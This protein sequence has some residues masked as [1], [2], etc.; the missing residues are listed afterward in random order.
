[1]PR[2][3]L[4]DKFFEDEV[5]EGFYIP[6]A[7]KQA[8][9]AQIQVFNE[10]D[11]VCETLGIKYFACSGTFLG[12]VRHGGFIPWDD[13]LDLCML[14][15]DYNRF[16]SEGVPL[17]P[18]GYAIFNFETKEDHTN[19]NFNVVAKT[20]ICFEPDH[21]ERFHGFPYIA[22]VD[23]FILDYI[24]DDDKEQELMRLKA[25]YVIKLS[26]EIRDKKLTADECRKQFNYLKDK[27]GICIPEGLNTNKIRQFLDIKAD[28][29]FSTFVTKKDKSEYVTFMM[30]W[31]IININPFPVRYYSV[32]VDM[33]FETGTIPV[34]AVYNGA[35]RIFHWD[36]MTIHKG[37]AVHDY[38]FFLKSRQQL[39]EVLDFELPEYKVNTNELLKQY[40]SR[41]SVTLAVTP[42]TYKAIVKECLEE[43][44]KLQSD[45]DHSHDANSLTDLC[46]EL[47]QLAIDLGSYMEAVKGNGYDIVTH[48]EAY[49]ESLYSLSQAMNMGEIQNAFTDVWSKF[50]TVSEKIRN[51]K[52]VVFMPFKGEYW[53][54][55]ESEYK[56]LVSDP[57]TDVY[58]VPIPYLYKDYLGRLRDMQFNP[59]DY[60]EDLKLSNWES[61]NLELHH[62]DTIYIQYPYDSYN[63]ITSIPPSFYS[64]KLLSYTDCLIYI[65]WFKTD[66]FTKDNGPEYTNMTYYCTVP[67]VVN[68]DLIILQSE[69]IRNTYIDKLC[70]FVGEETRL[71]WEKKLIV[72]DNDN[73][74]ILTGFDKD[75]S[76][77]IVSKN[78]NHIKTLLYYPD[79]SE[80]LQYK[81]NAIDKIYDVIKIL[82]VS[83]WKIIF[84]K[85]R[86]IEDMLVKIDYELYG[87]CNELEQVISGEP[88]FTLINE[89]ET[90]YDTLIKM[91]DAYYGDGGQL[92]HR[93]RNAGK[94]VKLQDYNNCDLSDVDSIYKCAD[95]NRH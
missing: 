1:M 14:R 41:Q 65:P 21:L 36:F 80:I 58:I 60:P 79:F 31:G 88:R 85:S 45:L 16:L 4:N 74:D 33:P 46:S 66:D 86:F 32:Q 48:L 57:D 9:G 10:I 92:A 81:Q 38:P 78:P 70:E 25:Q 50:D 59:L 3:E 22:A 2:I 42:E 75:I 63:P 68:S 6:S 5:R 39:Q 24:S 47:Q 69:T 17:L 28:E 8:W 15:D 51:R 77:T 64:D 84:L 95:F 44:I 30:P 73:R 87:K 37:L 11:N 23:L 71:I 54:A 91:C 40:N 7:I 12:A 43:M 93:F 61:F 82:K 29:L 90:D 26:D 94:P 89:S 34:P 13:D 83:S 56:K 53:K 52:E 18:E 55:F 67:G 76:V 19:F 49:C 27:L 62:P 35:L 72:A 20:R